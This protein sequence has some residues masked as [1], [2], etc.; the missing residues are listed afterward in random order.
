MTV[1][2]ITKTSSGIFVVVLLALF[3]TSTGFAKKGNG[4]GKPGGGGGEDPCANST[5]IFPALIYQADIRELVNVHKKQMGA[6][7]QKG[8][9]RFYLRF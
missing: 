6:D 9:S 2:L 1:K 5:A 3:V 7:I 8:K 4:G